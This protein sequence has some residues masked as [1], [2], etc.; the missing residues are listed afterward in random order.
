MPDITLKVCRLEYVLCVA[1]VAVGLSKRGSSLPA[2]IIKCVYWLIEQT[3]KIILELENQICWTETMEYFECVFFTQG[4]GPVISPRIMF[5]VVFGDVE[6]KIQPLDW[7]SNHLAK[8]P[9]PDPPTA[10]FTR[11]D[12][13]RLG[14][15]KIVAII[16]WPRRFKVMKKKTCFIQS[17]WN[18]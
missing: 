8:I 6:N 14:R 17:C 9:H 15:D 11:R 1:V 16:Q 2:Y 7:S 4:N 13:Q 3:N 5:L 18:E 10:P 12:T